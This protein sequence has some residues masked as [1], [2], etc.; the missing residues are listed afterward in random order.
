[1]EEYF[2]CVLFVSLRCCS[3]SCSSEPA[4]AEPKQEEAAA[5]PGGNRANKT[6]M[7][8]MMMMRSG[9]VMIGGFCFQA[10]GHNLRYQH[11]LKHCKCNVWLGNSH[12]EDTFRVLQL[13]WE[14]KHFY[15]EVNVPG[16]QVR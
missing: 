15:V 12:T 11:E 6:A 14:K 1:M 13:N 5:V 8:M 10:P 3:P 7:M 9:N 2:F 16:E 4:L